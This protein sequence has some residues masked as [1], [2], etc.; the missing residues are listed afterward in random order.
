MNMYLSDFSLSNYSLI[1][2]A[3]I[4]SEGSTIEPNNTEN[5]RKVFDT[6]VMGLIFCTREAVK[7][8][9][10]RNADGHIIHINSIA[11]HFLPYKKEMNPYGI[12]GASKF[13]VTALAEQ[14]RQEFMKEKLNIKV[15][16]SRVLIF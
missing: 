7:S 14:H 2:N 15:T 4:L 9:R 10:K 16:V 12:Y 13:A 3:G 1:N 5:M 11:G 8:I 6:N